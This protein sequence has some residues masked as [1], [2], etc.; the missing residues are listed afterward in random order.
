MQKN[1]TF[2]INQQVSQMEAPHTQPRVA[3]LALQAE[4]GLCVPG[5]WGDHELPAQRPA[6]GSIT[7]HVGSRV[8]LL[9]GGVRNIFWKFA[10]VETDT[11]GPGGPAAGQGGS[12]GA[13]TR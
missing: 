12:S 8:L 9:R 6:G 10:P 13:T 2:T 7:A 1:Y 3:S 11:V 5:P 4:G